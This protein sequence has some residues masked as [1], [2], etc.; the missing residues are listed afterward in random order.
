MAIRLLWSNSLQTKRLAIS[1]H[2]RR[3]GQDQ[4]SWRTW[5][6]EQEVGMCMTYNVSIKVARAMDVA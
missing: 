6:A 2:V 3:A 1:A 4:K 5:G